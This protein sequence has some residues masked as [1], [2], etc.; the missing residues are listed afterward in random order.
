MKIPSSFDTIGNILILQ[1]KT[2]APKKL[3]KEL[4]KHFPN[5]KTIV[6]KTGIHSGKYRL[7]KTK[8]LVGIKT[9]ITLHKENNCLLKLDIDKCYFSQRLSSERLRIAK[10]VKKNESILVMFD[11]I[12]PYSCVIS[13]NS[14]P[15][16]IY[17]IEINPS[18]NK[19]AQE[20]IQLNKLNNIKLFQG[21][22]KKILPRIKKKFD[23]LILDEPTAA[24]DARSEFEVFQRFKELSQGKTAVLISHRFSSVRMA[25]RIL[26]LANGHVEAAGTHDELVA[27]GGRYS[28]LFE[29][30]AA[31]Y[32]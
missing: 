29:L 11:G 19:F 1:E 16:E 18:C 20:N 26:V 8:H 25:D 27:Q 23:V 4:L 3:A 13:K 7:Q 5:I 24:L 28:E 32:R 22:V 15:K 30:Q 31:G 21:D 2:K 12:S 6:I 17:G 14:K 10:L 9:K